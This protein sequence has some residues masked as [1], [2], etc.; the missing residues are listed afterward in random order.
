MYSLLCAFICPCAWGGP[1]LGDPLLTKHMYDIPDTLGS[2]THVK[3]LVTQVNSLEKYMTLIIKV[4]SQ[5]TIS[6]HSI[7]RRENII[8][9]HSSANFTN[10][11]LVSGGRILDLGGEKEWS[12]LPHHFLTSFQEPNHVINFIN[13][14]GNICKREVGKI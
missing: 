2:P 8:P 9:C 12:F 4:S 3:S 10:G 1:L 7:K 5:I 14:D 11:K 6:C 13:H